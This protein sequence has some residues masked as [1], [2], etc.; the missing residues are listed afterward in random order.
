MI[1]RMGRKG[2]V[3]IPRALRIAASL[4]PGNEVAFSRLGNAIRVERVV[5]PDALM[6]CL[7]GYRLV[8]ALEED[9]RAQVLMAGARNYGV[10]LGAAN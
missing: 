10:A 5:S 3:V 7:A 9:R 2:Q 6:G 4:E 1:H 8:D